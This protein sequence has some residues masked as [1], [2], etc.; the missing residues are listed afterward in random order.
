[1]FHSSLFTGNHIME[2]IESFWNSRC[3]KK[4]TFTLLNEWWEMAKHYIIL[5]HL[6]TRKQRSTHLIILTNSK[7][8]LLRSLKQIEK[9]KGRH[10]W[11]GILLTQSIHIKKDTYKY[12]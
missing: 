8:N 2:M 1:M 10:K 3:N 11:E 9:R 12:I 4:H 7:N 5:G 6:I